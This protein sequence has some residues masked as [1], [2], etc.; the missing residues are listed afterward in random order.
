M[1]VMAEP[2]PPVQLLGVG[3]SLGRAS[4]ARSRERISQTLRA[5]ICT[6]PGILPSATISSNFAAEMPMYIAASSRDKPR[7]GSGR[8]SERARAI[9]TAVKL[10]YGRSFQIIQVVAERAERWETCELRRAQ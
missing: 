4:K 2:H 7:R 8:V 9:A 3:F 6:G 5:S 10:A 1:R